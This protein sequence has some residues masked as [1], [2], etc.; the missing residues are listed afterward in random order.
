MPDWATALPGSGQPTTP[1]HLIDADAGQNG[2][3]QIGTLDVLAQPS[4]GP[5]NQADVN[6][7]DTGNDGPHLADVQVFGD[8]ELLAPI[9]AL[10]SATP[11][12]PVPI[13]PSQVEHGLLM[14]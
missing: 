11:A 13:V 9:N 5:S 2:G 3:T 1:Q 8:R 6:I 10:D 4:S 7:I 14:V 12:D